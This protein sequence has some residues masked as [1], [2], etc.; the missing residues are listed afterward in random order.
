LA[1]SGA[2]RFNE[3]VGKSVLHSPFRSVG[4][5]FL[6]TLFGTGASSR[7]GKQPAIPTVFVAAPRF[8]VFIIWRNEE[9]DC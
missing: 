5:F 6:K 9:R 7:A 1:F 8:Q 2:W 3:I 4:L